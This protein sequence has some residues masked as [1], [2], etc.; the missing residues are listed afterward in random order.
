M[1][2]PLDRLYHY[3]ESVANQVHGDVVISH[4]WPHGS[5]KVS[6]LVLLR[7]NDWKSSCSLPW[8]VCHDQEP[9]DAEYYKNYYSLLDNEFISLTKS[10]DCWH[11]W[12]LKF[13]NIFDQSI[14]IH[15]ELQSA[16]VD[17]Y[18][19]HGFLPVYYWCHA[20]IA[21]DW[22]R[23]AQYLTQHKQ[24]KKTFLI[25]NRAWAGTR[26]YRIK[27][28]D[29]LVDQDLVKHCQTS[30]NYVDPD[31]GTSY[32]DYV[33]KNPVWQPNHD[34]TDCF[35]SNTKPGSSSA[36]FEIVDYEATDIEVVLE[37]LFDDT[38][39]QLTEKI[40]RPIAC[41]QPFILSSTAGS[42]SYLKNYGFRT[43]DSVWDESY[44]QIL[45]PDLRL[46]AIVRLMKEISNWDP[47]TKAIK[48]AQAQ[49]IAQYNKKYF[50]SK[51]FFDLVHCELN[52]NLCQAL[53]YLVQ[54]NT[55]SRWLELRKKLCQHQKL[56]DI[57]LGRMSHPDLETQKKSYC[58]TQDVMTIL[59]TAR[60]YMRS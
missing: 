43:Y 30:F 38:R 15:S 54:N 42:L 56:K 60:K 31:T 10:Y 2:I 19:S 18:K 37:T 47:Q 45:D 24:T 55:S 27:F 20:V 57:M 29:L 33:F 28:A 36:D 14:L 34:L 44:D 3:I 4:F 25:Y 9:L 1:S 21:L 13:P 58:K 11:P 35:P 16:N 52:T 51:E 53:T 26:E 40:L 48:L 46:Q 50:F 32:K 39:I 23:F 49:V 17:I 7:N 8:I 59:Q 41:Q 6:D 5:K 12:D 22:F